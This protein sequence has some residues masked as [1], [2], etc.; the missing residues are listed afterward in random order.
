MCSTSSDSASSSMLVPF[1]AWVFARG[2]P[3]LVATTALTG[4]VV[5]LVLWLPFLPAGGPVNYLASIGS[6]QSSEPSS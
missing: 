4:A 5:A 6:H 2:G 1:A 3:R